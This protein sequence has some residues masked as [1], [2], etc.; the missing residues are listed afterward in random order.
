MKKQD[1]WVKKRHNTVRHLV[2]KPVYAYLKKNYGFSYKPFDAKGEPYLVLANHQTDMDQ[3][4]TQFPFDDFCYPIA[5]EDIFSIPSGKLIKWL[6]NPI[7]ITKGQINIRTILT[8]KKV[9]EQK[10]SILLYPE[11]NRTYSGKTEY[12]APAIAKLAKT[13]KL[14]IAFL[15]LRG[16]YGVRP[17]WS[18]EPRR[19]K[20]SASVELVIT[21]QEY[22]DMT[23]EQLYEKICQ[24]LFV[25]ES[26]DDGNCYYSKHLAEYL[27]RAI[28][29]CPNCGVTHFESKGDIFECKTCGLTVK[30]NP[31]KQFSMFDGS[32]PPY[33]NVNEW[34]EAQKTFV[35]EYI[36]THTDKV[37]AC[38]NGINLYKVILFK[39][40]KKICK[41]ATITLTDHSIKITAKKYALDLSFDGQVSSMTVLG[42]NKLN[43]LT[44]DDV[45]QITGDK[46]FNALKYTNFFYRYKNHK[47]G[48]DGINQFLGL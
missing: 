41:K 13:L 25:D 45:F 31:N 30:Y 42:R 39:N 1:S 10:K 28:Y 36:P 3:F 22:A 2:E 37:I 24:G 5:S 11:G 38:D 17:R 43:I 26:K 23:N 8:C 19:G 15:V 44:D 14:P 40:K 9:A 6:I 32:T 4:I 48:N 21:P 20:M 33:Q 35:K 16:G 47:E 46:R 12:I 27:E 29:Y 34:Y 7:P 18:D